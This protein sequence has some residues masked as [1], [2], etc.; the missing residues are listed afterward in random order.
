MAL[1]FGGS[2]T[3]TTLRV[4]TYPNS[5]WGLPLHLYVENEYIEA[6]TLHFYPCFKEKEEKKKAPS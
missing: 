5:C 3:Q 4:P 1:G 6:H 2:V